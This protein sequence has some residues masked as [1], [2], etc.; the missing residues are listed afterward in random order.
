MLIKLGYLEK[1]C[2]VHTATTVMSL[3]KPSSCQHNQRW[4]PVPNEQTAFCKH[5]AQERWAFKYAGKDLGPLHIITC[6][7][8]SEATNAAVFEVWILFRKLFGLMQ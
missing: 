7:L 5:Q 1:P 3:G 4:S 2:F 8:F 6:I